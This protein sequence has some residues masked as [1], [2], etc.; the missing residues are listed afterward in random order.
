[1][2]ICGGVDGVFPGGVDGVPFAGVP[3]GSVRG[4]I[5]EGLSVEAGT[6]VPVSGE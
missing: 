4:G 6:A 2:R 3:G 5:L 1:M